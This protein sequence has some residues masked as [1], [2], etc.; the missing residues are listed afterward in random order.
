MRSRDHLFLAQW[1]LNV[2]LETFVAAEIAPREW[3][4]IKARRSLAH[5]AF[6]SRRR[7]IRVQNLPC[8]YDLSLSRF[9]AE[10]F[11]A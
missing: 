1:A 5:F 8:A 10:S 11:G 6:V 3:P 7:A 4:K 2:P 9:R